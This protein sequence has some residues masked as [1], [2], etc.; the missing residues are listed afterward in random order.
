ML[1][2]CSPINFRLYIIYIEHESKER[3]SFII[4]YNISLFILADIDKRY[5]LIIELIV[6]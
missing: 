1:M 5:Y 3:L 4:K 6:F 2:I